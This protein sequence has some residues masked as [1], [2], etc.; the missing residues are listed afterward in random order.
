M[1]KRLLIVGSIIAVILLLLVGAYVN[2]SW[3]GWTGQLF[4]TYSAS[5]PPTVKGTNGHKQRIFLWF[6]LNRKVYLAEPATGN[7]D[8][9]YYGFS[10]KGTWR[11]Y[12]SHQYLV[13]LTSKSSK[14]SYLKVQL[15]GK[16][17]VAIT[18]NIDHTQRTPF[19]YVMI[20]KSHFMKTYLAAQASE[21]AGIKAAQ[22]Y[23][24]EK[25]QEESNNHSSN[26][27]SSN[28]NSSDNVDPKEIGTK[29]YQLVFHTDEDPEYCEKDGGKYYVG[30]GSA[31]STIPFVI[32]GD[33][34][35]YW[36]Q[37]PNQ[38]TADGKNDEHT[39]SI[40]DLQ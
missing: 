39:I 25:R 3:Q 35:T 20:P 15:N 14:D 38:I 27:S 12:G 36:T 23:Q 2:N 24:A 34:V 7:T 28:E 10:A 22:R 8:N 6:G 21:K 11:N 4:G 31:D 32:N 16:N 13:H 40:N 19:H 26:K 37:D 33:Q 29:I 1:K 17:L 30:Q 9:D 18:S 5:N